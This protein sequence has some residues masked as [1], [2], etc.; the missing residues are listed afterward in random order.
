LLKLEQ[1]SLS[2][3]ATFEGLTRSPPTLVREDGKPL[4]SNNVAG[5]VWE[6][7]APKHLAAHLIQRLVALMLLDVTP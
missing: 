4:N 5:T 7:T 6:F 1:E 2:D 3:R